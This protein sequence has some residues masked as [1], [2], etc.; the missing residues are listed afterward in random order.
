MLYVGDVPEPLQGKQVLS[1]DVAALL[2]GAKFRGDFEERL[3]SVLTEV[4]AAQGQ[5]VL[6]VDELHT[7]VGA[8]A[9]GEGGMDAGNMLKPLLARGEL[10]CIG[11]TTLKE[12]QKYIEKDKALERRFQQVYVGQPSVIDSIS[13]L[14]GLKEKYELYHGV[15][16]TDDALIAAAMLSDRYITGRFLPDKAIDLVDEA[17]AKLNIGKDVS[18]FVRLWLMY[19]SYM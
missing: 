7:I 5:I 6:F 15:R 12:Y 4:Q 16:I 3:K 9:T 11:A 1:L 18:K 14:R 2:A 19:F 10:H 13:I 8:G 17:A